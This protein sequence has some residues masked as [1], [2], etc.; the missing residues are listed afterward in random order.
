[1]GMLVVTPDDIELHKLFIRHELLAIERIN[2]R[3]RA[4]RHQLQNRRHPEPN[5]HE[6]EVGVAQV[7]HTCARELAVLFKRV[8]WALH[9]QVGHFPD[10]P[11]IKWDSFGV[12][13]STTYSAGSHPV[14]A[15]RPEAQRQ[16]R[17]LL[18]S[19]AQV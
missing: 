3:K 8:G 6:R 9:G 13:G 15:V 14:G 17:P 12:P 16:F 10:C 4:Y 11:S 18:Q 2:P 7:L 1:M 5:P 19:T